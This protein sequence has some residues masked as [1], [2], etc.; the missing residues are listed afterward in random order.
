MPLEN[1]TIRRVCL[2]EVHCRQEEGP[3]IRPTYGTGLLDLGPKAMSALRSRVI[4]AFKSNAQCM[5][6]SIRK[7]DGGSA[8][9]NGVELIGK[10]DPGFVTFS[11]TFAD[12]LT[13]AQT[14]RQIPGGLMVVFD[15]TLGNPATPF[16][17]S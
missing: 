3:L 14:S 10:R 2:H 16:L 9:A 11:R 6:M 12:K 15:G 17:A 5:E 7:F 1:V 8:L 4:A 13:E